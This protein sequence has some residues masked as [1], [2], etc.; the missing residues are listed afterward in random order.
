MNG[1]T[2]VEVGEFETPSRLG[3]HLF[4]LVEPY[5]VEV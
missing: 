1:S 2:L 5:I 4:A 3:V